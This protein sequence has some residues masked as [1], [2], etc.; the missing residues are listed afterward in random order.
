VKGD[1]TVWAWGSNRYGQLGAGTITNESRLKPAPVIGLTDVATIS[2]GLDFTLAVKQDGTVWAWGRNTDGQ[3]GDRTT[4]NRGTPVQVA[5][6]VV[7]VSAGERH[8]LAV[9]TNGFVLAWGSNGYGQL[10]HEGST[11]KGYIY[12]VTGLKNIVAVAAGRTHSLALDSNGQVWAWGY[13]AFGQ[14]GD[15][16]TQDRRTPVKVYETLPAEV[17]AIAAGGLHSLALTNDGRV[18]AWG[19]NKHGQLGNGGYTTNKTF[20]IYLQGVTGVKAISAGYLHTV[21]LAADNSVWAWG[22]NSS[23]QLGNNSTYNSAIPVQVDQMTGSIIKIAGIEAGAY[24]TLATDSIGRAWA[25]GQ[26]NSGQLGDESR[27]NRPT[28]VPVAK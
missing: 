26:N 22:G 25:W 10:G 11:V 19:W 9:T 2:S 23:G 4:T 17:K 21:A 1:G 7:A 13:N 16:T 6:N 24:H 8:A 12:P 28:P 14:V 27:S 5:Q 20:P 3:L 15:W 18:Y